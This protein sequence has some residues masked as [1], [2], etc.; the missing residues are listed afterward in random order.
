[1]TSYLRLRRFLG[2]Q[3]RDLLG[4]PHVGQRVDHVTCLV[5]RLTGW[6]RDEA[7]RRPLDADVGPLLLQRVHDYQAGRRALWRGPCR[8]T[9][10]PRTSA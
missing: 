9:F 3:Q 4:L 10:R 8:V 1:M 7:R 6:A 2:G 5:Q